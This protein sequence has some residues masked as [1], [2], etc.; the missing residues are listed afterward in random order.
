ME[1]E[2]TYICG[3]CGKR[4]SVSREKYVLQY[5][6]NPVCPACAG[7]PL[8]EEEPDTF[9]QDLAAFMGKSIAVVSQY[10][11]IEKKDKKSKEDK[12]KE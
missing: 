8:P 12:D 11:K 9:T 6:D 10:V 7:T 4:I 1:I 2:R 3:K 5:K